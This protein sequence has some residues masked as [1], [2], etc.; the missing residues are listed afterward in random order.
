MT[1]PRSRRTGRPEVDALLDRA[2][3]EHEAVAELATVN[4]AEGIVSRARHADLALAH[5]ELLERNRRAE[6]E[7][8]AAT[9]AGDPDRVAAARLARDA[10]WATFDRFGRD[11]LRE[12]A[13]LLTADLE[14][15]DALL[16]RVRTA[17]SA[18]DAAHEALARS[19]GASENSEGSE[20][21]EGYDEG[22]G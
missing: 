3:A 5:Q 21:S 15:Q 14:R 8:E 9:A 10:A 6:A 2:D 17:W 16:S 22:Q 4:Q 11:L 18:E 13:Q 20:G 7:L 12:S 1:D 19:P